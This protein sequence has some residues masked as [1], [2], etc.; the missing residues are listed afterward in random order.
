MLTDIK[1]AL[2]FSSAEDVTEVEN[3]GVALMW[4]LT[5]SHSGQI[6]P[7]GVILSTLHETTLLSGLSYFL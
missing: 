5:H 4:N 2:T 3:L 1:S 6:R 7:S